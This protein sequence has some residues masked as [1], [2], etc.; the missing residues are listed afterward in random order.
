MLVADAIKMA[1]KRKHH[2]VTL[3]VK[4]EALKELEKG[5]SNKDVAN[6]FSIPGSTL[7]TWKKRNE[8]IFEALQNSSLK[9]QRVKTATYEKLNEALLKWFTSMRGN[10]IPINGPIL[11]EKAHASAKAFNCNDFTA[12]NR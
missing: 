10:N 1:T 9:R 5:R 4:Y 2:E 3:K 12:S 11:L 7:A 6:Q 8:N